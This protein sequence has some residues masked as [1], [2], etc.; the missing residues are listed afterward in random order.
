M[1]QDVVDVRF[2]PFHLNFFPEKKKPLVPDLSLAKVQFFQVKLNNRES[3]Q[4][5]FSA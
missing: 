2:Q 1:V 4:Q 5:Y 3:V